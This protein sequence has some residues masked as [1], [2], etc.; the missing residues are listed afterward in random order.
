M[1]LPL[2]LSLTKSNRLSGMYDAFGLFVP[3]P[4]AGAT[5]CAYNPSQYVSFV[6]RRRFPTPAL[7]PLQLFTS[8]YLLYWLWYI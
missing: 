1:A 7:F 2:S 8:E 4:S 6:Q 5:L 3:L